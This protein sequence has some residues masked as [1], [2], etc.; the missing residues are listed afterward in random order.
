MIPML[1]SRSCPYK[2]TF[3]FHSIGKK[4]RKRSLDDFF[5]EL[6]YLLSKY[7]IKYISMADE[8][9]LPKFSDAK[10]FC[11]RMKNYDIKW[12]ADFSINQVKPGLLP[13]LKDGGCDV[14]FFGLESADNNILKSMKKGVTIEKTEHVLKE[15]LGSGV[16]AYGCF[17]FGDIEE[18]VE[19]ANKT[20][21]WWKQHPEY[22]IHLTL[23][24]PFPGSYI[25]DYACRNDI[26]KDKVKYL[27]D[28]CPQVNISKMTDV[29]FAN[30]AN[31]ISSSLDSTAKIDSVKLINLDEIKGRELIS[32]I[33]PT[34][35][36]NNVWDA[37]L[38]SL[39]YLSCDSCGLKFHVPVPD[40]LK[41]NIERNIE[42]LLE[43]YKVAIWGM[44]I[45]VVQLF[46]DAKVLEHP[47]VYPVDI[48]ETKRA[49]NVVNKKQVFHPDIIQEKN[50]S[51][52]IIG[53]PSHIMSITHQ[54][55]NNYKEKIKIIDICSLVSYKKLI[56]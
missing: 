8:L 25:Y 12:Y 34:C 33:C 42:V 16:D 26:I 15:M 52:V 51:C 55:I 48:S 21:D 11:A 28:G 39:D 1:G 43:K 3:C 32:G 7:D 53:V 40:E 47:H 22:L 36:N 54:I 2:C 9:F 29:E 13:V 20:L 50:I 56:E 14:I 19:S 18:T 6:D 35:K 45:P 23:I 38:F 49:I 27:Y 4:Y 37:K 41:D 10:E 5:S 46:S 24:K 30:I 17:I 44:T 31:E